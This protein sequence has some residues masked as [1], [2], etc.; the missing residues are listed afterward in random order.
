MY[1]KLVLYFIYISTGVASDINYHLLSARKSF[2]LCVYGFLVRLIIEWAQKI[3]MLTEM[4]NVSDGSR[5]HVIS[6]EKSLIYSS[7]LTAR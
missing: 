1:I 3:K 4:K 2:V 7:L 5:S 6:R